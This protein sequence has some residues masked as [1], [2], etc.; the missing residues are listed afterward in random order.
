MNRLRKLIFGSAIAAVGAT[1]LVSGPPPA[2]AADTVNTST[3]PNTRSYALVQTLYAPFLNRHPDTRVETAVVN[4]GGHKGNSV[5]ARFMSPLTCAGESCMTVVLRYDQPHQIWKEVLSHHTTALAV[6]GISPMET[7]QGVREVITSDGISWR[8]T[9]L[10]KYMPEVTSVGQMFPGMRTASATLR[11]TVLRDYP[12]YAEGDVVMKVSA[13]RLSDVM[14]TSF[15]SIQSPQWC[16]RTGCPFVLM[17]GN[18]EAGYNVL[19]KGV[20][21]ERAVIMNSQNDGVSDFAVQVGNNLAFYR[22][23]K[24]HYD[25]VKTTYQSKVSPLP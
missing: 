3:D 1:F 10:G 17:T 14:Q 25:L 9:S 16:G 24:G 21:A 18:D 22:F 20:F 15:V 11:N 6:G 4:L 2:H 5:V 13:P 7:G 8:W 23:H 19:T 12:K